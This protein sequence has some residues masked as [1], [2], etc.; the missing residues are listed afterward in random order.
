MIRTAILSA[1][2]RYR[3]RLGRQWGAGSTRLPWIMLNPSTADAERDDPTIRRVIAFSRAWGYDGCDIVNLC[4][5]RST[6]PARLRTVA[7]PVG[8]RNAPT[9]ATLVREAADSGAMAIVVAWGCDGDA[10]LRSTDPVGH[11]VRH[12]AEAATTAWTAAGLSAIH[13]GTTAQGAPRH[14]LYVAGAT[15][16]LPY[17]VAAN[18][19]CSRSRSA[20][21]TR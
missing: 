13:L 18:A 9:I 8:P 19:S 17:S 16:P 11:R 10:L 6:D 12:V 14:P 3:Y 2:G 5:F 20:A 7:N 1:D 4:A 15:R 21:L